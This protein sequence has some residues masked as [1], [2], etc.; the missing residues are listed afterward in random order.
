MSRRCF[1]GLALCAALLCIGLV[2][3]LG[4]AWDDAEASFRIHEDSFS[5]SNAP[6]YC[7]A[8]VAFARWYYLSRHGELPLRKALS[9]AAQQR[10]AR[11]LQ[12]FY[13]QNLIKLQADY[14]N[15]HHA[16]P[17]ES[18]RRFLVGLLSG[19]PQIVLLMNKG[20]KG[21]VLHAVLAY[22]WLPERNMLKVYDPNYTREERF[23]DL[24]KKWY[25]S[26]DITYNA[27]C[28]PEVLNAHPALVR[29]MEY[30]YNRYA[31]TA[32]DRRLAGPVSRPTTAP[33]R[34]SNN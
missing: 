5:I 1:K 21:A 7:F 6:G 24:D 30:L 17:S 22:E 3:E 20:S 31:T 15:V 26:L 23:I 32:G 18:F 13:S 16:N 34:Q 8:M 11:E 25:T 4:I 9:P 27:I 14:C 33:W 10:I 19:E 2:I 12:E 29:R 28:F